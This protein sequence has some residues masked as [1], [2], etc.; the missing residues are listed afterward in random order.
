MDWIGVMESAGH[1]RVWRFDQDH[2]RAM[3]D[4][5]PGRPLQPVLDGWGCG[6]VP[7]IRAGGAADPR[8][9][10][11]VPLAAPF[12]VSQMEIGRPQALDLPALTQTAPWPDRLDPEVVEVAGFVAQTPDF[13]G[14]L[15]LCGDGPTR[16]LHLSAGELV[17]MASAAT[18]TLLGVAPQIDSGFADALDRVRSRPESLVLA[19]H[20]A[21][22]ATRTG[23]L[24]GAE[25]TATRALWLGQPVALRGPDGWRAAYAAGLAAQ[26]VAPDT[27]P[28]TPL[29]PAGFVAAAKQAGVIAA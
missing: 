6:A 28:R 24:I 1:K 15:V 4:L 29:A 18:P 11:A 2:A 12:P 8:P 27:G 13:D 10:P 7:V 17:S 19:L 25:L 22:A 16:W 3:V 21:D 14:I 5:D 9:L 20:G 23:A 26:G